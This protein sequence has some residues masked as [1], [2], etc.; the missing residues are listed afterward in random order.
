MCICLATDTNFD[1]RLDC[2]VRMNRTSCI[3]LK[4][5]ENLKLNPHMFYVLPKVKF[6]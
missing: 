1:F 4:N 5:R 3:M 6:C 2:F